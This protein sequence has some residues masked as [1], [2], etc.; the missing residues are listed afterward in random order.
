MSIQAARA[1]MGSM[2]AYR[3]PIGQGPESAT[4]GA[5]PGAIESGSQD[6]E[7]PNAATQAEAFGDALD[8]AVEQLNGRQ[9]HAEDQMQAF[10]LGEDIPVHQVMVALTQAD[11]SM[12][13]AST[14]TSRAISAYQEIARMQ[15]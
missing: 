9:V 11:L 6:S 12:R 13:L 7:R 2:G 1:A 15:I 3:I 4:K 5:G 10:A 8:D 14:V